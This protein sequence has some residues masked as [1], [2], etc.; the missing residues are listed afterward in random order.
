MY[1]DKDS[2]LHLVNLA[3]SV[4]SNEIGTQRR[5]ENRPSEVHFI[6]YLFQQVF[7]PKS[8]LLYRKN[9]EITKLVDKLAMNKLSLSQQADRLSRAIKLYQLQMNK[10]C[11]GGAYFLPDGRIDPSRGN[12]NSTSSISNTHYTI[13]RIQLDYL[14]L[15]R[16]YSEI[17]MRSALNDDKVYLPH[18]VRSELFIF[19]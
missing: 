12:I 18:D 14:S 10:A 11:G 13:I 8:G 17:D 15:E 4:G 19:V 2:H 5:A 9:P 1:F 6:A 3:G 7:S 16:S